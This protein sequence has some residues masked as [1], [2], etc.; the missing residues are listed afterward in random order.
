MNQLR[1]EQADRISNL[2]LPTK[3]DLDTLNSMLID[4]RREK[5]NVIEISQL[6]THLSTTLRNYEINN[7]SG[8]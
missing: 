3:E 6:E 4:A 1:L 7:M 2:K 5:A 8:G